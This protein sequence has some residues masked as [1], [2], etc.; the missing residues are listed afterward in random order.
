VWPGGHEPSPVELQP[1]L[2]S[3][4]PLGAPPLH[5]HRRRAL[6][7]PQ[8]ASAGAPVTV[9]ARSHGQPALGHLARSRVA[10][11]RRLD[12]PE[13]E[14]PFSIA[15]VPPPDD[16]GRLPPPPSVLC[17]ERKKRKAGTSSLFSCVGDKWAR[18]Y[19]GSH[20]SVKWW[21]LWVRDRVGVAN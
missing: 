14:P 17:L 15:S 6:P 5:H 9:P 16:T 18:W 2:S 3:H 21:Q 8:S 4:G 11:Q 12:P 7:P 20:M 13:F 1:P 10:P 19:S